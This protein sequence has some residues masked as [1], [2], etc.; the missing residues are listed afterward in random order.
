MV[1]DRVSGGD[2]KSP[3]RPGEGHDVGRGAHLPHEVAV[4]AVQL[5]ETPAPTQRS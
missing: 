1:E 4:L 3:H 5:G 2:A